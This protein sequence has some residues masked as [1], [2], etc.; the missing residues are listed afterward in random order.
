MLNILKVFVTMQI[1]KQYCDTS[2]N[3]FTPALKEGL[4][5]ALK[6][7]SIWE[8]DCFTAKGKSNCPE[9]LLRVFFYDQTYLKKCLLEIF[10]KH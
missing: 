3:V 10:K 1:K 8:K 5:E 9:R 6:S 4:A 2:G 7:L